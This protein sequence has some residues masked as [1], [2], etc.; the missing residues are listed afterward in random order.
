V[1]FGPKADIQVE[2]D[3]TSVLPGER[4]Q[5]TI[6]LLGGR[7][8]LEIQEGR[9]ELVYENEYTYRTTTSST[10][11][12]STSGSSSTSSSSTSYSTATD[13]RTVDAQH[14]LEAGTVAADTPFEATK[15]LTVPASAPPSGEG[16]ITKVRWKIVATLARPHARD[17]HGEATLTVLSQPGEEPG[18]PEVETRDDL[19]LSFRLDRGHFGPGETIHGTLVGTPL[20]G[21][22]ANEVRV[23][24]VRFENVPRDEGNTENVKEGE[25]ILEGG[26]SLSMG[27]PHEWPFQLRLPAAPVP[28][29]RTQESSV[30]WLLKGVGSRRL[31]RDYQVTQPIDVHTA[32]S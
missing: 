24:L 12:T 22:K 13:R 29:L 21:C 9:V 25:A 11:S 30:T 1:V 32:P 27:T 18:E 20:Q 19:E 31:R 5:A 17:V 7:E 23:E 10:S 2:L 26:V 15:S 16:K 28:S 14:F 3:R 4:V 6:R 8:D